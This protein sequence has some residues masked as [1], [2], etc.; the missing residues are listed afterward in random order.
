[1]PA[2]SNMKRLWVH[3]ILRVFA[4]R[5]IDEIDLDW[6]IRQI[7][8]TLK[9]HIEVSLDDLFE[10]LLPKELKKTRVRSYY[11]FIEEKAE[12]IKSYFYILHILL[13]ITMNEL[14]NLVYC[15]FIDVKVD[16][17]LY[18]EVTD[19]EQ[20]REIVEGYLSEY[21]AMTKKPMNLVLFR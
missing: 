7:G 13:Q 12:K 16:I 4:D 6:L 9:K 5:L 15:D 10:D 20:L 3:E 17:R 19:L 2:L 11:F 1:M 21:N 8:I 14:R 18:Q